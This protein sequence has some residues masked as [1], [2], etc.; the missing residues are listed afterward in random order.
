M[1]FTN[2]TVS[3]ICDRIAAIQQGVAA[4][5]IQARQASAPGGIF[6]RVTLTEDYQIESG[7]IT[8][9]NNFELSLSGSVMFGQ[10]SATVSLVS[11]LNTHCLSVAQVTFDTYLLNSGLQLASEFAL[12][13]NAATGGNLSAH[14]VFANTDIVMATATKIGAGNWN[15]V[16]G[17]NLGNGYPGSVSLDPL[18]LNTGNC[19]VI[20]ALP[21]GVTT[22]ACAMSVSGLDDFGHIQQ[23]SFSFPN[24]V[25]NAAALVSPVLPYRTI[26]NI[27]VVTDT[28]I[29]NG[30]VITFVNARPRIITY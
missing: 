3:G 12:V 9:A 1:L 21:S 15:F 16:Q 17:T 7:F 24:G 2:T 25:A 5:L 27:N 18:T 22:S 29:T 4:T 30:S 19:L 26:T 20:A 28:G 14:N 11:A 13:Y 10:A 6:R 23:A 8:P